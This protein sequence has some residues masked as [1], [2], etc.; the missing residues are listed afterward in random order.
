MPVGTLLFYYKDTKQE[1]VHMFLLDEYG[2][3]N[4]WVIIMDRREDSM[5]L[6]LQQET[7]DLWLRIVT[8]LKV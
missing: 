5:P 1:I 8:V 7:V 4:E 3:S 6:R 2:M